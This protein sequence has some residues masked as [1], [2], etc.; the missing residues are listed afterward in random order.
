[1]IN[2]AA[3]KQALGWTSLVFAAGVFVLLIQWA[4]LWLE[5]VTIEPWHS[6]LKNA[7]LAAMLLGI[8]G[9]V[10][11]DAYFSPIEYPGWAKICL[12]VF[13]I[14]LGCMVALV[15]IKSNMMKAADPDVPTMAITS[16]R[17]TWYR[18]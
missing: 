1:M 9:S 14:V 6:Y 7:G 8:A 13:P 18:C 12:V 3:A 5:V 17:S 4:A 15:T 2:V 16:I 10:L 11:V